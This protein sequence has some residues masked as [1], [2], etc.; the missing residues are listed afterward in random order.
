MN[1]SLNILI[2]GHTFGKIFST[3]NFDPGF[4]IWVNFK[5]TYFLATVSLASRAIIVII[6]AA[7]ITMQLEDTMLHRK[8]VPK[9]FS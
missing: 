7:Y 4:V 8:R 1:E 6:I 5:Y 3:S 9:A 2:Q